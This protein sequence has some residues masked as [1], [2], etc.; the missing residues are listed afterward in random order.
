MR[1]IV[2]TG[3]A[4]F[5]G[6]N[7]IEFI[8]NKYDNVYIFCIDSLTYAG[9]KENLIGVLNNSRF[10]FLQMSITDRDGLD[11]FFSNNEID[12]I[13]N[14]A[15]ESHVDNS[16]LN[17]DSFITSNIN[18]T[19][20]LLEIA[21]KYNI[22]RLHQVST[23][24]VYGYLNLDDNG[25][26][27]ELSI[28]NPSSPYSSSKASADLI[29]M[30]YH[31]T[32]KMNITISRCSNNYGKFQFREKLIP[33]IIVNAI[34]N[35]KIPIYGDGKNVRDWIH[36]LDHCE[37]IDSIIN[38]GTSGEIYNVAA[39]N[40]IDN[41]SIVKL[42]L[43]YLGKSHNLIEYVEDRLGHDIRYSVDFSKLTRDTGWLP[44]MKF[45]ESIKETI[46]WFKKDNE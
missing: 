12:L 31:K 32:Y 9:N 19:Y 16:I 2:I 22:K 6:A 11:N 17:P 3:G 39:N 26:F 45:S 13:V 25:S 10:S 14:F 23:D 33:K 18:G 7:F 44:K 1:N 34:Q 35:K 46:D 37:A 27:T 4:G 42:I 40:E 20:E 8:L 43:D 21:K 36:V 38:F 15:A 30:A 29:C 41:N 5:I 28:L 24:E